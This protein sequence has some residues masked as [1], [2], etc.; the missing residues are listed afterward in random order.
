MDDL[1]SAQAPGHF[2]SRKEHEMTRNLKVLGLALVA[3]L[4]MTAMVASAASA[5]TPAKFTAT[6]GATIT[7]VDTGKVKFTVT[8][9][10]VTCEEATYSGVA[11]AASFESITVNATF[12]KC[13]TN[14]GEAKVTGFGEGGCDFKLY[15]NGTADLV[16]PE[17]K[18]VTV[19]A[20]TCTVHIGSAG[21]QGLG[22][23]TYTNDASGDVK[24]GLNV[25]KIT[26]NHTDGFLCP[27]GS[28]GSNSE[29]VLE[30]PAHSGEGA[31]TVPAEPLTASASVG[32]L[33]WDATIP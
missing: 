9:Q 5:H 2:N 22:T 29:G 16:C 3:I 30:T 27:F 25:T 20:L 7:A 1:S 15:A 32:T 31:N 4:A 11:P 23:L 8:G 14:F 6:A 13:K 24:I 12:N 19:D 18:D 28:S 10:E 26:G 17:G 21:N 33:K